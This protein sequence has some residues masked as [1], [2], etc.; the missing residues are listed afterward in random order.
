MTEP[1]PCVRT[2]DQQFI[3]L[4]CMHG[5][6]GLHKPHTIQPMFFECRHNMGVGGA[7][8]SG[9]RGAGHLRCFVLALRFQQRR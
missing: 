7:G 6:T 4:Q 3:Q 9:W 1:G 5:I 8:A 2:V